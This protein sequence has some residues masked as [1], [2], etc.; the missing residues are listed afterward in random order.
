M[1]TS[2]FKNNNINVYLLRTFHLFAHLIYF[3]SLISFFWI[4]F[5]FLNIKN[6]CMSFDILGDCIII[7]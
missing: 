5:F 4:I 1:V 6:K 7:K 3:K 2:L